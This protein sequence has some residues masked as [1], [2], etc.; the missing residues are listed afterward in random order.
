MVHIAVVPASNR[1]GAATIRS[2][3][4][5]PSNPSVKGVYRNLAKVPAE[6]SSNSRFE[7]VQG[8][9]DDA[10]TL[11]F[12]GSDAVLNITPTTIEEVDIFQHA[13]KQ[14]NNVKAAAQRAGVKR[15]VLLSSVGAHA[16]S[17]SGEIM[18][19]HAAEVA[20]RDA[21]PETVFVRCWYFTEN[22]TAALE[23]I[24]DGFFYTTITP[25]D[26]ALPTIAVK[27]IGETLAK[28]LVAVGTALP[29]SPY[30][31]DLA[32]PKRSSLDVKKAFEEVLG[33]EIEVRP[34]P[35]EDVTDFYCA[36]FPPHVAKSYAEMT[37]AILP[38]GH[39]HENPDNNVEVRH[40]KTDLVE[41]FKQWFG[42]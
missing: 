33:K 18:T 4:A 35:K 23:T 22:W 5:D 6:F 39:L 27:D 26:Y 21:A 1:T 11:D 25:L 24:N 36:V 29:S 19:N 20:L 7:A 8:T 14:S 12:S 28:E 41:V 34:V 10:A 15:L 13:L 2:L 32:G 40:G 42:A 9:V 16:E 17:G 30:I 3:L 37:A 38:G 31:F